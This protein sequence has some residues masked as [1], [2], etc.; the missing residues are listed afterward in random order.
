MKNSANSG[1]RWSMAS[2]APRPTRTT[3]EGSIA[4]VPEPGTELARAEYEVTIDV[5]VDGAPTTF[6]WRYGLGSVDQTVACDLFGPQGDFAS[7]IAVTAASL[8]GRVC[9]AP[10]F[11]RIRSAGTYRDILRDYIRVLLYAEDRYRCSECRAAAEKA[12]DFILSAQLPEPQCGW[13][14]TYDANMQPV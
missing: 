8:N 14:Q 12:G 7:A 9:G 3:L 11:Y 6:R 1:C 4:L 13:A 5:E 2:I 10:D